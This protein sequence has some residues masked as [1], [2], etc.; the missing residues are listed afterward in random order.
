MLIVWAPLPSQFLNI[1]KDRSY[2]FASKWVDG[3][4]RKSEP[5]SCSNSGIWLIHRTAILHSYDPHS[6]D[7]HTKN[8]KSSIKPGATE[9]RPNVRGY[10]HDLHTYLLLGPV[11]LRMGRELRNKRA[12]RFSMSLLVMGGVCWYPLTV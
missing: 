8:K 1:C 3:Q 10:I 6:D 4:N 11:S 12:G 9:D 5:M 7:R 2:I